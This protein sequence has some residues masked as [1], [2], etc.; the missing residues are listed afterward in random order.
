MKHGLAMEHAARQKAEERCEHETRLRV[1][2][3]RQVAALEAE[4]ARLQD[5]RRAWLATTAEALASNLTRFSQSLLSGQ[6]PESLL[7]G[8]TEHRKM[9]LVMRNSDD[10]GKGRMPG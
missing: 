10:K 1:N 3:E 7:A 2:A 8:P 4:I 9:A 6:E 5:A